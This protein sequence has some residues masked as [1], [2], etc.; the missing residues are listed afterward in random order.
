ML[1]A[2]KKIVPFP[3][4]FFVTLMIKQ[5]LTLSSY[6]AGPRRRKVQYEKEKSR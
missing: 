5:L 3:A 2:L 6:V 1:P 4:S